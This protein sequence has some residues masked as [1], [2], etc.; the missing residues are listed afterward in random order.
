M[1]NGFFQRM[2][3]MEEGRKTG[4]DEGKERRGKRERE[5]EQEDI[6]GFL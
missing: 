2:G 5:N 3:G 6:R 4:G 1:A